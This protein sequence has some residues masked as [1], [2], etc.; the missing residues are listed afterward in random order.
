MRYLAININYKLD[1]DWYYKCDSVM[2]CYD[3]FDRLGPGHGPRVAIY[4]MEKKDYLWIDLEQR[5]K[6]L[7]RINGIVMGAI[8]KIK[9]QQTL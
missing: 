8:Q 2:E 4:D 7:A 6:N 3:Y 9:R 1:Q 5:E